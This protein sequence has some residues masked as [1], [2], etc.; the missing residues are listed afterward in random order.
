MRIASTTPAPSPCICALP[1]PDRGFHACLM[2][3]LLSLCHGILAPLHLMARLAALL[4]GRVADGIVRLLPEYA[5]NES[6]AP[7]AHLR[8]E[9][10]LLS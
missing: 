9:M 7:R 2:K 10:S 1:S 4:A 6:G 8:L 5:V 3:D